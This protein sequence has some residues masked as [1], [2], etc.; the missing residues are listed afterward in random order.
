MCAFFLEALVKLLHLGPACPISLVVVLLPRK[1]IS[2]LSTCKICVVPGEISQQRRR[3][4]GAAGESS[5]TP[6]LSLLYP[7]KAVLYGAGF[8][9]GKQ[10]FSMMVQLALPL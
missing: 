2:T 9:L 5:P 10:S 3:A 8:F 4:G 7:F 1:R 6:G